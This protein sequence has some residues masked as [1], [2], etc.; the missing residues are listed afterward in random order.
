MDPITAGLN[1]ANA[2]VAL[3]GKVWDATPKEQQAQTAAD[4]AKTMHNCSSFLQGVQD[5]INAAMKP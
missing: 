1:L 5:K 3:M 2:I 4:I